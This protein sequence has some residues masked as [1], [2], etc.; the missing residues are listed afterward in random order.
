VSAIHGKP[1]AIVLLP[2]LMAAACATGVRLVDDGIGWSKT[3]G[4]GGTATTD[5]G[6]AGPPGADEAGAGSASSSGGK[7]RAV[8]QR[9]RQL[10]RRWR[11]ER[12]G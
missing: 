1:V 2:T 12:R 4:D 6:S 5:D 9:R 10:E 3:G 7:R 8:R 11:F